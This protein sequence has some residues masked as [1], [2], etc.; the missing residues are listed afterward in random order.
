MGRGAQGHAAAEGGGGR[1]AKAHK[2]ETGTFIAWL[3]DGAGP[4]DV[5]ALRREIP[6]PVVSVLKT[7][8][9]RR[10]RRTVASVWT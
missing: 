3:L 4:A 5:A 9:G 6:G 8:P 7:V 2:G 10:Y 1:G